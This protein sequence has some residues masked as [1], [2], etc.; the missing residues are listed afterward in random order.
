MRN[1]QGRTKSRGSEDEEEKDKMHKHLR[2][3]SIVYW[4]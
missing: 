4:E 2:E 1:N 3:A